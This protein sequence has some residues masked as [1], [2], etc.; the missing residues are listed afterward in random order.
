[1]ASFS[2][3]PLG[4]AETPPYQNRIAQGYSLPRRPAGFEGVR[5]GFDR[6]SVGASDR[7]RLPWWEGGLG[8]APMA[9]DG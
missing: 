6:P 2:P 9:A 5:G 4:L 8:V 7:D 3:K 1:M